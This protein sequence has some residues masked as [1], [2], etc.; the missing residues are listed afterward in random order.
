MKLEELEVYQIA[1]AISDMAWEIY[2]K[3]P[4]E[5]K[6]TMNSQFL[7]ASDSIGANISEGYGRYHYKD[8]MKFY[9][10]ARG[11]LFESDFWINRL[12]KRQFI[13]GNVYSDFLSLVNTEKIKL[14]NFINSIKI[15]C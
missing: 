15:K 13:T 14:N 12:Y 3:L 10:T 9:Y 6:Y 8:S 5:F 1:L 2:L 11:S 4:K 7:D